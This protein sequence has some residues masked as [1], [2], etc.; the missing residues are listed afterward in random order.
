MVA[1]LYRTLLKKTEIEK[2]YILVAK[3]DIQN[4]RTFVFVEADGVTWLT[5]YLYYKH[6]IM[7]IVLFCLCEKCRNFFYF[8]GLV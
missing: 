5:W 6:I 7:T 2:G 8:H 1:K 3:K 4:G